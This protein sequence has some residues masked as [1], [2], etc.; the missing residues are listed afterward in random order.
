MNK[1]V[2]LSV[3]LCLNCLGSILYIYYAEGGL[4]LFSKNKIFIFLIVLLFPISSYAITIDYQLQNI[5][6]NRYQYVYTVTNDGSLGA[7][8]SVQLFDV[9]FDTALY[10]EN[11]LSITTPA[12]LSNDW[13]ELILLPVPGDPTAYDAFSATVG[14]PVGQNA[15]GFT[16]QFDWLGAGTPSTQPFEIYDPV[17]FALLEAGT[18]RLLAVPNGNNNGAANIPTLSEW[19]MIFLIGTL[20]IVGTGFRRNRPFGGGK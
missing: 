5:G 1:L 2:Y 10:N 15:T 11:T 14:I 4:T 17:T 7:G 20:F 13:D 16:V 6:G 19:V 12:P 3:A 9:L 8:V 18:T